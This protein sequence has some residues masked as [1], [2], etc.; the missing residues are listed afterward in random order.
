MV[1]PDV[2]PVSQKP[3]M[4]AVLQSTFEYIGLNL[5]SNA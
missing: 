3:Q 4:A 1:S 2:V 5:E